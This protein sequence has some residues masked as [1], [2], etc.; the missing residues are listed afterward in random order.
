METGVGGP[1]LQMAVFCEKVLQEKDGVIS[2]IRI[3]D[4]FTFEVP[5]DKETAQRTSFKMDIFIVVALKSG[6]YKGKKQ[7]KITPVSPSGKELPGFSGPI[8]LEKDGGACV[9][10]R[11][12]FAADE[13]GIYWFEVEIDG[14]L[15]TKMP[16]NIIY[17]KT[18][19]TSTTSQI[20]N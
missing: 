4:S 8:L 18:A 17:Q 16:M 10:V 15:L 7:L 3:V 2:P 1:F 12:L 19:I 5:S 14:E 11:F 9:I 13:E 20:A 6:D